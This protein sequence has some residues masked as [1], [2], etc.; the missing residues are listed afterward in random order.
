MI[1]PFWHQTRRGLNGYVDPE[2]KSFRATFVVTSE[3]VYG[4]QSL[5]DYITSQTKQL[6]AELDHFEIVEAAESVVVNGCKGARMG[7]SSVGPG[8]VKIRQLQSLVS[9]RS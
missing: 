2:G 4:R 9:Q 7:I 3:D 6:H 1:A 8:G 5:G